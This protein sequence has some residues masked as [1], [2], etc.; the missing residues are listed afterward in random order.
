MPGP[1][2][3]RLAA[4]AQGGGVPS[5]HWARSGAATKTSRTNR[6]KRTLLVRHSAGGLDLSRLHLAHVELL[7]RGEHL[8]DHLL[9]GRRRALHE[10]DR[11]DARDDE[12]LEVGR[13]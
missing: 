1:A 7:R 10:P 8:V 9:V 13:V 11:I 4:R 12:R 3:A 6:E 5:G 2:A